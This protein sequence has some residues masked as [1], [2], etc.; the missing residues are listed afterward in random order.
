MGIEA[1]KIDASDAPGIAGDTAITTISIS[2]K[3]ESIG[4]EA[5]D[6]GPWFEM[7]VPA[8]ADGSPCLNALAALGIW[9]E[10]NGRIERHQKLHSVTANWGSHY[11]L[12]DAG[13]RDVFAIYPPRA[14]AVRKVMQLLDDQASI[15][16]DAEGRN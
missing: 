9:N 6:P 4:G 13:P 11:L 8:R 14:A 7:Q 5:K 3:C 12:Y 2:S 10:A 15:L 16:A 1:D